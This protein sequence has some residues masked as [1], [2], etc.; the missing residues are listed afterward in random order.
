VQQYFAIIVHSRGPRLPTVLTRPAH[1][2]GTPDYSRRLTDK[3]RRHEAPPPYNPQLPWA[4]IPVGLSTECT[5]SARC[6][7]NADWLD[8]ALLHRRGFKLDTVSSGA[9]THLHW[10]AASPTA[11]TSVPKHA[12]ARRAMLQTPMGKGTHTPC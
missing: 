2:R 3:T 7:V 8:S 11:R 9:Y 12:R 5:T 1:T 6:V 10:E 4:T